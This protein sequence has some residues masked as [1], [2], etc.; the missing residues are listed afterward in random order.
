MERGPKSSVVNRIRKSCNL[1]KSGYGV[2]ER[3]LKVR[4]PGDDG[5]EIG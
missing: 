4:E 3:E 1:G 5:L 2:A